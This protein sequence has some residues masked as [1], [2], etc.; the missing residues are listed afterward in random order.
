MKKFSYFLIIIFFVFLFFAFFL[1]GNNI[2]QF[3][4]ELIN[5]NNENYPL[6]ITIN[7][8]YFLIALPVTPIILANGFFLGNLGF[9]IIYSI[10]IIDSIIIFYF[11]KFIYKYNKKNNFF[12]KKILNNKTIIKLKKNSNK[13]YIFIILRYILPFTIH[14]LYYGITNIS[15][16]KFTLLVILSEFPLTYAFFMLG[17]SLKTLS[18]QNLD[19]LNI[20]LSKN[21][22]LPLILIIIFLIFI[23]YIKSRI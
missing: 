10:I 11:S 15:L 4:I 7:F 23:N 21:F 9:L 2:V 12:Q 18:Y 13:N 5:K 20:F 19:L 6:I 17:K 22:L 3:I 14:N 8:I 16:G 1:N